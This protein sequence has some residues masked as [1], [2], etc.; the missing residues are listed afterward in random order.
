MVKIEG[1]KSP[2]DGLYTYP[3]VINSITGSGV[4]D[5]R[6]IVKGI[7]DPESGGWTKGAYNSLVDGLFL[8]LFPF[9]EKLKQFYLYL[10]S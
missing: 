1:T 5:V 3:D 7:Y 4:T 10:L 8:Y 6:K 2:L 9:L